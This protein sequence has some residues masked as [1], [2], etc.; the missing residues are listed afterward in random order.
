MNKRRILAAIILFSLAFISGC[1][2]SNEVGQGPLENA[3]QTWHTPNQKEHLDLIE[4]ADFILSNA[5]SGAVSITNTPCVSSTS[6]LTDGLSLHLLNLT[7]KKINRVQIGFSPPPNCIA[8]YPAGDLVIDTRSEPIA[9]PTIEPHG[10]ADV[11]IPQDIV[12]SFLD[13]EGYRRSCE[14]RERLPLIY[15][16]GVDFTDGTKWRKV[17]DDRGGTTIGLQHFRNTGVER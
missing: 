6:Y 8:Y 13:P 9:L 10:T 15:I 16:W 17:E 4:C 14:E 5:G 2:I 12:R 3:S 7:N 1:A 11:R